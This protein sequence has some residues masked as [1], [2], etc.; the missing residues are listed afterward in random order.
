M[1]E[2]R[3]IHKLKGKNGIIQLTDTEVIIIR[4][5]FLGYSKRG[6]N[7][8]RIPLDDMTEVKLRRGNYFLAGFIRFVTNKQNGS[9]GY[10]KSINDDHAVAIY[11]SENKD[12]E[13]IA[14]KIREYISN[15]TEN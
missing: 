7:K 6:G 2:E 9:G 1:M 10:F 8:T 5:G 15:K 11:H 3:I 13:I 14:E 4:D 12:A